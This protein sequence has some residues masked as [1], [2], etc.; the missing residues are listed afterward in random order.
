MNRSYYNKNGSDFDVL[1]L[2]L[3]RVTR[4]RVPSCQS[5]CCYRRHFLGRAAGGAAA[6]AGLLVRQRQC[7]DAPMLGAVV[8]SWVGSWEEASVLLCPHKFI[9]E[10]HCQ[11]ISR[12]FEFLS[13]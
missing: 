1:R 4:L 10:S 6:R 7:N 13:L 8:G 11:R 9:S 2:R 5:F 12:P 3:F